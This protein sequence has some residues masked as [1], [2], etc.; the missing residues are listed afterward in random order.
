MKTN[1]HMHTCWCDGKNTVAEMVEAA[2]ARG[3]GEVGFS[4]HAR[5]PGIEIAGSISPETAVDYAREVRRVAERYADR[6]SVRLGVEADYI[7]GNTAP[8]RARYAHL[9]LDYMIGSVHWVVAPDGAAVA[10]DDTPQVLQ[11]GIAAHF[12]GSAEAYIRA[13]YAQVRRM[14]L[15]FDFDIVGHPDLVRKFNVRN[16]YFDESSAWYR[17]ELEQT[18]EALARSGKI[19]EV[20]TGAISRGWLND[21]YPSPEFRALLRARSVR[22]ILSSDAHSTEG[23]DC[24]FDRFHDAE[25]FLESPWSR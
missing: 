20:N 13:Y 16:P 4:S 9:G 19:V 11:E 21:A 6:I 17:E 3:F 10:V 8:E 15:D 22:F 12:G 24:A 18:A 5:L 2:I 7:P 1:Y 23:I 14:A 25:A